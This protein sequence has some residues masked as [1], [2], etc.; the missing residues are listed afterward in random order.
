MF[1]SLVKKCRCDR[2][3]YFIAKTDDRV[4][5]KLDSSQIANKSD[6]Y[7]AFSGV[8]QL[9]AKFRLFDGRVK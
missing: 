8:D 1:F 6:A 2:L 5:I 9:T 4:S 3:I 7:G